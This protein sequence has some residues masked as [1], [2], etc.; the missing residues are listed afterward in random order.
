MKPG[1]DI[2]GARPEL[3]FGVQVVAAL[4]EKRGVDCVVT[5]IRDGKHGAHSLHPFG[6]AADLRSWHLDEKRDKLQIVEAAKSIL[7][8][9]YDFVYEPENGERAEHFHLEVDPR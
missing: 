1:V 4:F 6:Y 2:M 5:S 7:G 9:Q 3:L 8:G